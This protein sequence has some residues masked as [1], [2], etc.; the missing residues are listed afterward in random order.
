MLQTRSI[1][2]EDPYSYLA[3]GWINHEWLTE[4]VFGA[5]FNALGPPGLV[6][7]KVVAGML[8]FTVTYLILSRGSLDALR[9]GIGAI[10]TTWL[11]Y[12]GMRP[13]RPQLFTYLLFMAV[14]LVLARYER[15]RQPSILLL[16]PPIFIL[17]TNL[18]GGFLAGLGVLFIWSAVAVGKHMVRVRRIAVALR[19]AG[20]LIA[21]SLASVAATLVNPYGMEL[22]EFLLRTATVPR[23][24]ITEWAPVEIASVEGIAYLI[25]LALVAVI[26]SRTRREMSPETLAVLAVTALLPLLAVRH[27]PL[28]GIAG[29][30]LAGPKA[31][32]AFRREKEPGSGGGAHGRIAAVAG[33]AGILFVAL[34]LPNFGCIR[35][36][37]PDTE[38]YPTG[39]VRAL[40]ETN[41][42]MNLAVFFNWGEYLIWHL[43]PDV[44]VS[45]D[46]RRETVYPDSVY[47]EYADFLLGTGAWDALL[48]ERP[49][50]AA[51]VPRGYP[52]FNLLLLKPGWELAYEDEVSG[53][54]LPD[55]SPLANSMSL[56]S[57]PGADDPI[58]SRCFP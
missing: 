28:F 31:G 11:L 18:H 40:A 25:F 51:L 44:Q 54:F 49:T 22:I 23:P 13:V 29:A 55:A 3:E 42:A 15:T 1:I 48:D 41:A 57:A 4:I 2:R 16:L 20:P 43:G 46:G 47:H 34:S 12:V 30:V 33:V 24:E 35:V 7:L 26:V 32:A 58:A 56:H 6:G 21:V 50:D 9:A 19:A 45:M 17:W 36:G 53:L 27:V 5:I 10:L 8:L 52:V 37:P 38:P 14:L 39:A